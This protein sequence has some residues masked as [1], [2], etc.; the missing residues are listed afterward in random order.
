MAIELMVISWD[1]KP[2]TSYNYGEVYPL[3]SLELHVQV[4][5][6]EWIT[7]PNGDGVKWLDFSSEC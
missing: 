3:S 5:I 7:E 2:I 1:T 6:P 4:G